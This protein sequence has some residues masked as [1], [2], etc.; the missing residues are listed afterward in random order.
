MC[1]YIMND[2]HIALTNVYV[3]IDIDIHMYY[4]VNSFPVSVCIA[5][6]F[7]SRYMTILHRWK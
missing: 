2:E 1:V 3:Y 4:N 5:S 7:L 6:F